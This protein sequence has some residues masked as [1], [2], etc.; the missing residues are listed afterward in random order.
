MHNLLPSYAYF[1]FLKCNYILSL[2]IGYFLVNS[3][4]L[5]MHF[6]VLETIFIV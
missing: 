5:Q 4:V 1:D 2:Q 6:Y 3:I